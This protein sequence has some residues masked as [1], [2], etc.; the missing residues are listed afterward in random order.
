VA[1]SATVRAFFDT[2]P[3]QTTAPDVESTFGT[4]PKAAITA[5]ELSPGQWTASAGEIGPFGPDPAPAGTISLTAT[6]STL[7][8]DATVATPT[9]DYW[10]QSIDPAATVTPVVL[11]PGASATLPLVITPGAARG[12]VVSGR[13]FVDTENP[14]TSSG[15]ELGVLTYHYTVG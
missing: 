7:A 15:S 2:Y 12:T 13:L 11:P 10:R 6:V 5:T 8:F 1:G 4:A 14:V 3:V 9:G